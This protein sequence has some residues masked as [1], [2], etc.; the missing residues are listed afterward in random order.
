MG[1]L[2]IKN[3]SLEQCKVLLLHR[4]MTCFVYFILVLIGNVRE[5]IAQ[6]TA[7]QDQYMFDFDMLSQY[8]Y[9]NKVPKE[10]VNRDHS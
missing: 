4:K 9:R 1:K 2:C 6:A 8:M 5:I 3:T 7:K 10:T